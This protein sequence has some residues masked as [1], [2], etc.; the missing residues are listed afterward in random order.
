MKEI[1]GPDFTAID[2]SINQSIGKYR[3]LLQAT[4][5]KKYQRDTEDYQLNQV[6]AW[7]V[8]RTGAPRGRL[9]DAPLTRGRSYAAAGRR[10]HRG[11]H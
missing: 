1:L 3:D 9:R 5:I 11:I 8:P 2:D 7:E 4:K 10:G 6:Y